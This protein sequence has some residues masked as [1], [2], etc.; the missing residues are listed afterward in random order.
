MAS[1]RDKDIARMRARK[2]ELFE[3]VRKEGFEAGLKLLESAAAEL[4]NKTAA[5]IEDVRE[6]ILAAERTRSA[7][8]VALGSQHGAPDGAVEEA[9]RD[10][11]SATEFLSRLGVEPPALDA[12]RM[13]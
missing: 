8:L 7:A 5:Y 10:G 13:N 6:R 4:R 9:I 12:V 3:A 2:P 11:I 1:A